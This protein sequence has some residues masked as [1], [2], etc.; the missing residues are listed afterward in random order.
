MVRSPDFK[1]WEATAIKSFQRSTNERLPEWCYW[2]TEIYIPRSQCGF[3]LDNTIKAVHDAIVRAELA[4]D[5]RY[6]VKFT[7]QFWAGD[8]LLV[9]VKEESLE[10]WQ[11]IMKPSREILRKMQKCQ[12]SRL[13]V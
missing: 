7:P 3:D 10:K 12:T 5:D 4:P 2:A 9:Y 11:N 6:I 8:Y 13:I 1:A